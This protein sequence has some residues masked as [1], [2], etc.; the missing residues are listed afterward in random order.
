MRTRKLPNNVHE[1]E[2]A[3]RDRW[4]ISYAD[5][6]TLLL[7]LFIVMYAASDRERAKIIAESF[8][9]ENGSESPSG[10][11]VLPGS[12]SVKDEEKLQKVFLGNP[13]LSEKA[14]IKQTERGLVISI[15]E[16]GFFA[17]GEAVIQSETEAII[18]TLAD[19][20]KE[21]NTPIRVEGHTDA[22]PISNAKYSSNWE[23]ST[24]RA[25]AVLQKLV[26]FGITPER[27]S[28]AGYGGFQ[29][30]ADNATAEGRT[31]NRRV[32]IVIL[33]R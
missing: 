31:Q 9:A 17:P 26:E 23:L 12:E 22:T 8:S 30:I 19:S 15:S 21:S 29:P 33:N 14:K 10:T 1:G 25:S 18:S 4:L 5:L 16:A 3:S 27:L 7:A 6:I 13:V 20:L 32:D 24:A 11:G 28:A 2:G